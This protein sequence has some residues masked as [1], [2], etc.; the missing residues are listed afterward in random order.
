MEI[1]TLTARLEAEVAAFMA[2][3]K[4]ADMQI[5][6]VQKDLD[7]L[8]D[9]SIKASKTLNQV[10][11]DSTQTA[12][13][14]A[15]ASE[16]QKAVDGVTRSATG[17]VA[18]VKDV[19]I[20]ETQATTFIAKAKLMAHEIENIK[21]EAQAASRAIDGMEIRKVA[22]MRNPLTGQFMSS[23]VFSG[24]VGTGAVE[25]TGTGQSFARGVEAQFAKE[26]MNFLADRA[27]KVWRQQLE[28]RVGATMSESERAARRYLGS[29]G[30]LGDL[31]MA[32]EGSLFG[33]RGIG[34]F[35]RRFGGFG[36]DGGDRRRRGPYDV[37]GP[38][39]LA[40]VLPGGRRARPAALAALAGLGI[41]A[42]PTLGPAAAGIG[43]MATAGLGALA[44]TVGT[45]RLAFADLSAKAFTSQKAFN[46]LTPVQKKFVQTLRSLDAGLV[47]QLEKIAQQTVIP[48]LTKAISSA[49]TPASVNMMTKA[50]QE[51]STAISVAAQYWGKLL[52]SVEFSRSFGAVLQSW[53]RYAQ[54]LMVGFANLF[55]GFIHLQQAAI[56]LT[57]WLFKGTLQLSKWFD[58]AIKAGQASGKLAHFFDQ[59]KVSLQVLGQ[60]VVN[61]GKFF[62]AAFNAIGFKNSLSIILLINRA[63]ADLTMIVKENK[64]LLGDIFH[65]LIQSANDALTVIEALIKM[66]SRLIRALSHLIE[67][68]NKATHGVVSLRYAFDLM[69]ALSALRWITGITAGL[70]G[71]AAES[72]IASA[73]IRGMATALIA[74]GSPEVLLALAAAAAA[75]LL[76]RDEMSHHTKG[77]AQTGGSAKLNTEV[78]E[79]H[80]KYYQRITVGRNVVTK[81]ISKAQAEK[82]LGKPITEGQTLP[83]PAGAS[84][85]EP[86]AASGNKGPPAKKL[87]PGTHAWWIAQ[88]GFDPTAT[89]KPLTQDVP[90]TAASKLLPKSMQVALANAQSAGAGGDM[91]A[92]RRQLAVEKQTL[93]Y[94]NTHKF[95]AKDQAAVAKERLALSREI[96][97]TEKQI[98]AIKKKDL[99]TA[100]KLHADTVNARAARIL[101]IGGPVVPGVQS[102]RFREHQIL[103]NAL[104][105]QLGGKK[106]TLS[107]TAAALGISPAKL[108]SE[109]VQQL[110]KTMQSHGFTFSKAQLSSL[111]KI[112]DVLSLALKEHVKLNADVRGNLSNRLKQINDSLKQGG[113]GFASNYVAVH[114]SDLVKGLG[115]TR[116]QK[117]A[118]EQRIAQAAAHHMMRPSGGAA[119][120]V[121]LN[122]DNTPVG[123]KPPARTTPPPPKHPGGG[124]GSRNLAA[125]APLH[126]TGN[127]Y[128][129]ST[130]QNIDQLAREVR[131]K[132]LKT[133][134]RNTAQ[135]RGPN[136]GR[137][138][139]LP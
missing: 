110:I 91:A 21:D 122:P 124:G 88:V 70:L 28:A 40:G 98:A 22:Q 67:P 46:E 131:Q 78:F 10:K 72:T 129:Y 113:K 63:V 37:P 120:G 60:L 13:T 102:L 109:S 68:L 59:A 52:G 43:L 5:N 119:V 133:A 31:E 35:G 107:A 17:A 115:L 18:E 114:S 54:Q 41:A 55:D 27:G 64:Q 106:H 53:A 73:A 50:V 47:K 23:R 93:E 135:T 138:I 101:G 117:L 134:R 132:L 15:Y 104:E 9:A 38:N 71:M 100:Q 83:V 12:A 103:L 99:A 16:M 25:Q 2:N 3:M 116:E 14:R 86:T 108:Q 75:V 56:P 80:G 6:S 89:P 81:E 66:I 58:N 34:R 128:I 24:G 39:F 121:P 19:Q 48:G 87:I 123:S 92:L 7:E 62:G 94:I 42:T 26:D 45:L 118:A 136:A 79:Q 33:G 82:I 74:L 90:T 20:S 36:S 61:V 112:N 95:A 111:Q 77:H 30:M 11:L 49:I 29:K 137:N 44:G 65:A 139:G 126:V 8:R 105:H 85:G 97:T 130:A 1:A 57:N 96:A 76:I 127:I 84:R 69:L 32:S 125:N 51:F 4:S